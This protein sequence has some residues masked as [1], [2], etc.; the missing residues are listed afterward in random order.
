M[1]FNKNN[2]PSV[3]QIS[4]LVNSESQKGEV[5]NHV[6]G[7]SECNM[8]LKSVKQSLSRLRLA[9]SGEVLHVSNEHLDDDTIKDYVKECL[10][11][12]RVKAHI[13]GCDDCRQA[14]LLYRAQRLENVQNQQQ[15]SQQEEPIPFESYLGQLVS[16]LKWKND[17][18]VPFWLGIPLGAVASIFIVLLLFFVTPSNQY[19]H[20][21]LVSYRDDPHLYWLEKDTQGLAEFFISKAPIDKLHF[22]TVSISQT[23]KDSLAIQWPAV[24]GVKEYQIS[25]FQAKSPKDMLIY[26]TNVNANQVTISMKFSPGQR[27]IW[28]LKGSKDQLYFVT[29]GGFLFSKAK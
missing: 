28:A 4:D 15:N 21:I 14:V 16:A 8:E 2:H 19:D 17:W 5:A 7:C 6:S 23:G 29:R 11:G 22:D 18:A 10:D 26:E 13:K 20:Q 24:K 25:L 3:E 27:Y 12:E 9:Y 1:S